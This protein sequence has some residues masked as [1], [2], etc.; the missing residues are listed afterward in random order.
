MKIVL[1]W[2]VILSL[3]VFK[4]SSL[5]NDNI[6]E[7]EQQKQKAHTFFRKELKKQK[8]DAIIARCFMRVTLDKIDNINSFPVAKDWLANAQ[9]KLKEYKSFI[10]KKE[11]ERIAYKY[12]PDKDLNDDSAKKLLNFMKEINY[13]STKLAHPTNLND[14]KKQLRQCAKESYNLRLKNNEKRIKFFK[15]IFGSLLSDFSSSQIK[16]I[17]LEDYEKEIEKN[18]KQ[19]TVFCETKTKTLKKIQNIKELTIALGMLKVTYEAFR[20]YK[21]TDLAASLMVAAGNLSSVKGPILAHKTKELM[22]FIKLEKKQTTKPTSL[23]E[24][25]KQ[26]KEIITYY[27]SLRIK[28]LEADTEY[29]ENKI[30]EHVK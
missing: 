4:Y 9:K 15:E 24:A 11:F 29:W 12:G 10:L 19:I 28:V 22:K 26:L 7:Y 16:N 3:C 1:F 6:K 18:K 23:I 21:K 30:L 8:E 5:G 2:G 13:K 14:A 27:Y 20:E 25:K 17:K